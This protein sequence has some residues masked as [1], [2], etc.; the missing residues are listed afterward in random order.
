MAQQGCPLRENTG[1]PIQVQLDALIEKDVRFN[2]R[3]FRKIG[4]CGHRF[5]F[6]SFSFWL[7]FCGAQ[8]FKTT[9]VVSP[10]G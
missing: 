6:V 2:E 7:E 10:S 3:Y 1:C 4:L 9:P 8:L 5:P